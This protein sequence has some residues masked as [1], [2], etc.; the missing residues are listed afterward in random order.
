M[1]EQQELIPMPHAAEADSIMLLIE[2]VATSPD[3]DVAK[4]QQLMEMKERWDANAALKAFALDFSR[5]RPHLP[6]VARK[7]FNN[8]TKS[9][10][11]PLEDINEA[12]DPILAEYGFATSTDIVAQTE[13]SV[14]VE[15]KLWHSAGHVERTRSCMPL[16]KAGIKGEINKTGPWALSSS[17]QYAKRVA[18]CAL[19]NISTGD[20]VDG[21]REPEEPEG[22]RLPDL[23][24]RCE[25]MEN[26][27]NLEE[28][29]TLFKAAY[30]Q[31]GD[32]RDTNAQRTLISV[33][34]ARKKELAR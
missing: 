1:A 33:K 10:Y 7:K 29:Q 15:A 16:D 19:L 26:A 9:K 31:A 28:L 25:W 12:V 30:K 34:D 17:V 8:Q 5:M 21:N 20:D 23:Q 22:G 11:A 18:I 6:R 13:N 14:T 4:L 27:R 32:L 24:E 2:K 3:F